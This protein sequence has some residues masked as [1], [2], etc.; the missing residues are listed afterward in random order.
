MWSE[1]LFREGLSQKRKYSSPNDVQKALTG[2]KAVHEYVK[3]QEGKESEKHFGT[4][5][6]FRD[7]KHNSKGEDNGSETN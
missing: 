4:C 5:N 2:I 1:S 7:A 6:F 3:A